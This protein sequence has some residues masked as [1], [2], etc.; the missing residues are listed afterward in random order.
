MVSWTGPFLSSFIFCRRDSTQG[1]SASKVLVCQQNMWSATS[2][3]TTST[4][5]AVRGK[6]E[7]SGRPGGCCQ[8][9]SRENEQEAEAQFRASPLHGRS[10]GFD[11]TLFQGVVTVSIRQRFVC[12]RRKGSR[13]GLGWMER[14]HGRRPKRAD[15]TERN[16]ASGQAWLMSEPFGRERRPAD[17]TVQ[18][19]RRLR[20]DA[21]GRATRV[22]DRGARVGWA[23]WRALRAG[24]LRGLAREQEGTGAAGQ[25]P[26]PAL[27][28]KRFGSE[29]ERRRGP[30]PT[31]SAAWGPG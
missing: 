4:E 29:H 24:G 30:Q 21:E 17:Q 9:A 11:K 26:S 14:R 5:T 3:G 28:H 23:G 15:P 25:R 31:G 13:D 7:H 10:G 27:G 1:N 8:E 12:R 6:A 18:S 2:S 20:V 22:R 19:R 16:D